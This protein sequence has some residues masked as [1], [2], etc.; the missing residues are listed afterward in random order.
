MKSIIVSL[1]IISSLSTACADSNKQ[2]QTKVKQEAP[3]SQEQSMPASTPNQNNDLELFNLKGNVK[4]V[5]TKSYANREGDTQI[6]PEHY[7]IESLK[8]F[9][10][11]GFLT[12]EKRLT[13]TGQAVIDMAYS[14]TSDQPDQ[15]TVTVDYKT[16]N[17]KEVHIVNKEN[18]L[19]VA[20]QYDQD[21]NETGKTEN[22]L[23]K[24]G[25]IVSDTEYLNEKV[26]RRNEYKN[27]K[28]GKPVERKMLTQDGVHTLTMNY[29]YDAAGLP[30]QVI[31]SMPD[32]EGQTKQEYTHNKNRD[33]ITYDTGRGSILKYEYRYDTQ[34]NWIEK[35]HFRE[36]K[37]TA[38]EVREIAYY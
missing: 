1:T 10:T 38:I 36:G 27:N 19:I 2:D 22:V 14:Y 12:T 31:T 28:E 3:T 11:S 15:T 26:T 5:A 7:K 33:V 4:S 30:A 29:T 37:V 9:N 16:K 24:N 18:T 23:D 17:T 13:K 8:L 21:G 25:H 34:G 32:Q 35:K 20:T 6:I